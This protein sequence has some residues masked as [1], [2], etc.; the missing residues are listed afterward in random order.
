MNY[1]STTTLEQFSYSDRPSNIVMSS[2]H[3]VFVNSGFE[4]KKFE[5]SCGSNPN[6]LIFIFHRNIL[7]LY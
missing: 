1:F 2:Y 3:Q 7:V 6:P 5:Y 4:N